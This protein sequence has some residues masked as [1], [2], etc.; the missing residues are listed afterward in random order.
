MNMVLGAQAF[1]VETDIDAELRSGTFDPGRMRSPN[2]PATL[3][4]DK[5]L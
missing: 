5:W 4:I 1:G 2:Y 3:S